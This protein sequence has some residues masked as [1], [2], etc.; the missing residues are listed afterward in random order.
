MVPEAGKLPIFRIKSSNQEWLNDAYG[1]F[2][3][4]Y[5]YGV[6]RIKR[7]CVEN[8]FGVLGNLVRLF[9]WDLCFMG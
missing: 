1:R 9:D 5:I 6:F 8:P 4:R 7:C 3:M 2:K